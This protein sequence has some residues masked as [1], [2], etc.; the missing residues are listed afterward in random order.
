MRS[1]AKPL[2]LG[3]LWAGASLGLGCAEEEL[4]PPP[5]LEVAVVDVVQRDQPV[6]LEMVGETRGSSD[7]PIRAR[8]EG[9]LLE[10]RFLEGINIAKGELLYMIDPSPFRS[11]VVEE[12][13]RLA[14]ASTRLSKAKSDLARIRPLAEMNAVSEVELDAAVAA[15][16]AA[17][18]ALQAAEARLEQAEIELGYTRIYAPISGR[19]GISQARE[20]EFVGKD[21]NPVVLNYISRTDPIR[22]RF[23]IDER[24]YLRLA[25]RIRELDEQ[26]VRDEREASLE[27]ILA[28][29]TVHPYKGTTVGTDASVDPKTGTFTVEADFPNPDELVLAGQFARVRGSVE[30]IRDALLVPQRAISELQG[31]FRVF[32]V[33][34]DGTVAMRQVELGPRVDQLQVV[35]QGLNPGERVA[36]DIIRLRPGM[37]VDPHPVE[38]DERGAVVEPEAAEARP[39]A[40][41]EADRTDT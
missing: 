8:V 25:R 41:S 33:K 19:I 35:R 16:D 34:D 30:T 37:V 18:G 21:P 13:G 40:A 24:R 39:D 4:P 11:R 3:W 10:M 14:E 26:V 12:Q 31:I 15:R 32:L 9:V 17:L 20:G 23:S 5:P 7:I 2:A 27:L 28:D 29:G 22:V 38:I 1:W 36:L 6:F